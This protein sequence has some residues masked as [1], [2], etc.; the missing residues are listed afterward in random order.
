MNLANRITM[1]RILLAPVFLV[2]FEALLAF[3]EQQLLFLILLAVIFA[4]SEFSDI[5]DGLVARRMGLTSSLGKLLDPFSD[6]VSRLTVFLCLFTVGIAPWWAFAVI[7][8]RELGMTFLRM[9]MVMQGRVQAA[10]LWGKI[11]AWI[12][13][14]A[15]LC[16]L[17]LFYAE[18]IVP[19]GTFDVWKGLALGLFALAAAAAVLSFIPYWRAFRRR[20][21]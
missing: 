13:F 4:V 7:L 3:P 15:S 10:S 20:P 5:L 19:N 9:V 8:Y 14:F 6:V 18:K 2:L 21:S 11:K 16:G 17:S 1:F 12:Y